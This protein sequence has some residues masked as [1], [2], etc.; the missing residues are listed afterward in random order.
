MFSVSIFDPCHTLR[1]FDVI[2]LPRKKADDRTT[3]SD[4]Q[5]SSCLGDSK[6]M[7]VVE[8][9]TWNKCR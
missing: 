6:A 9:W 7:N 8:V 1:L 5:S 3:L 4:M 2:D